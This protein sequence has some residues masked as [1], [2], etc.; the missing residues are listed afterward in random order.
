ML[1]RLTMAPK[2]FKFIILGSGQAAPPLATALTAAH[3]KGSTLIVEKAFIGGTCVNYGF[4]DKGSVS[5]LVDME[6]VRQRKRDIVASFRGGNEGRL[7]KSGVVVKYGSGRF[8]TP[9]TISVKNRD[10]NQEEEYSADTIFINTGCRPA[11]PKLPG[12]ETVDAASVLDSTSIMELG[13]V[14]RK[15]I[16]VGAGYVGLEFGQL[17]RRLGARVTVVGRGKQVLAREDQ[18]IADEMGKILVEDGIELQLG[19]D[20]V[21]L[22][23]VNEGGMKIKLVY[24][25]TDGGEERTVLG[26]H[27]LWSA[28]RV[29]N[30]DMLDADKAGVRIDSKGFVECDEYLQTAAEGVYVLG[31]VKGGPAFTHISYDDFRILKNNILSSSSPKLSTKDRM[32]PY[33]VYTDPQLGHIGL[34]EHEARKLYPSRN[35]KVAKMPMTWVARALETDETR[36]M[37]KA[38]VDGDTEE[39]LGYTCLGIEGGEMMSM[40]Q[41]A[42]MGKLSTF[43]AGG[44]S[45][46]WPTHL[47]NQSGIG[48]EINQAKPR[49]N[50]DHVA[51][52]STMAGASIQRPTIRRNGSFCSICSTCSECG[53]SSEEEGFP[54][55]KPA[56]PGLFPQNS[57]SSVLVEDGSDEEL[58]NGL[59][60]GD[61]S[62]D[63]DIMSDCDCCQCA[64]CHHNVFPDTPPQRRLIP[65]DDDQEEA[66]AQIDRIDDEER[67]GDMMNAFLIYLAISI[68]VVMLRALPELFSMFFGWDAWTG[69]DDLGVE[70]G[71]IE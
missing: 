8:I 12:I 55:P 44:A 18:D 16:V 9:K 40:V 35:I 7:E 59:A 21:R 54:P 45:N 56:K 60:F 69:G 33:T 10:T 17:F 46:R 27:I 61:T 43:T 66:R 1:R 11:E 13:Q 19:M 22:E 25:P 28:G 15:L 51:G 47:V 53:D 52:P 38:V 49:S 3:G 5:W 26:S 39:I 65:L 20:T 23:A 41:I 42:M 6:K 50:D 67:R 62:I 32:V 48:P 29:P 14:P 2:H 68:I 64:G 31:D 4:T 30:T 63:D 36:G 37:M 57:W 34:H 24:K 58:A 71:I 70:D